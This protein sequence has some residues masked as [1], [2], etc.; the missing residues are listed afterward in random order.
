MTVIYFAD[1]ARLIKPAN[2]HHANAIKEFCPCLKAGDLAAG[3][4]APVVYTAENVD[5]H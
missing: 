3:V 5:R 2:L 4:M 1:G